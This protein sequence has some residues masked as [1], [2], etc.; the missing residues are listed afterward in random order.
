M[1]RYSEFFIGI[2]KDMLAFDQKLRPSF[3]D[4][5]ILLQPY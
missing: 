3:E 2:I 4:L 5:E 1:S